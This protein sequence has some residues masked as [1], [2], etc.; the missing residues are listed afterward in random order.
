VIK[1]EQEATPA[2]RVAML[3]EAEALQRGREMGI[4]DYIAK[5]NLFRVLLRHPEV[6]RELNNTI[7]CLVSGPKLLADRLREIIIMRVSWLAACDYEWSQHWM[8]SLYFGLTE[9]ELLSI[10][11]WQNADCFSEAERAVLEA[12]D[13]MLASGS[14][15]PQVWALLAEQFP[16]DREKIEVVTCIANWNMFAQILRSLDIPLDEGLASWP[17]DGQAP[18]G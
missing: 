16:A 1:S 9:A 17:P 8:A 11:D 3:S 18:T 15:A 4:D 12:T 2:P 13:D 7:I 14:L 5:M 10:R 6:A